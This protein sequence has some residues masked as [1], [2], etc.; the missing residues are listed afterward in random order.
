MA[1]EASLPL[2]CNGV[3]EWMEGG[4]LPSEFCQPYQQQQQQ[5]MMMG[6]IPS[7]P[8][9]M[10]VALPSYSLANRHLSMDESLTNLL[11][12]Q[13]DEIDQYLLLQSN[14]LRAA[15]HLQRKQ[16]TA[17]LLRRLES[18][19]SF[20]LIQKESELARARK[21]TV[22]LEACLKRAEEE[23]ETWQ[24][25]AKEKEAIAVGLNHALEQV[26][27]P[28][29]SSTGGSS[30]EVE[31]ATAS[32]SGHPLAMEEPRAVMGMGLCKACGSRESR[33]L[34]LP[35]RHLSACDRCEA[36][37]DACPLCGSIKAGSVEVFLD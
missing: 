20:L 8:P 11:E 7:H 26:C 21:R 25:I 24:R 29:F 23:R 6:W 34:L 19:T 37:L 1:V 18:K 22:E 12:K 2:S 14:R 3:V 32:C 13:R 30:P 36:F 15:L 33:V 31:A 9:S 17:S 5:Q 27:Q 35:C 4:L 10:T 16:H 28:C